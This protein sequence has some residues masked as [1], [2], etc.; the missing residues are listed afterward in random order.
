MVKIAVI[1][2][3]TRPGRSGE[4]VAH[5]VMEHAARRTGAEYALVDLRD[6]LLPHLDEP[7][8][9]LLSDQYANEHTRKWGA[10]IAQFDGF[11]FVTPEYNYSMP[12]VLKNVIDYLSKEW[13]NK[14]AGFVSYGSS[15]GA[16]AVEQLRSVMAAVGIADVHTSVGLNLF[17]DFEN[18]TVFKPKELHVAALETMLAEVESWAQALSPLRQQSSA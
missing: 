13:K 3:S 4:A 12:G 9:A 7:V 11:V 16:R 17:Y 1:L 2:G 8:P 14:A 6:H 10:T 15:N 5:W 18:L